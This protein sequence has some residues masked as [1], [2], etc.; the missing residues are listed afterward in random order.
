MERD[1]TLEELLQ[2]YGGSDSSSQQ[3]AQWSELGKGIVDLTVGVRT[4]NR[5]LIGAGIGEVINFFDSYPNP[6]PG[7][8]DVT[9]P[10]SGL[11]VGQGGS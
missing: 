10:M 6:T 7:P 8:G 4:G 2:V 1:L 3:G 5:A 9:D 11:V